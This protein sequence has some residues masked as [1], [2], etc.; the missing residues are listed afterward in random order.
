MKFQLEWHKLCSVFLL[1]ND[2][3]DLSSCGCASQKYMYISSTRQRWIGF[4]DGNGI[5]RKVTD[6]IMISI[7]SSVYDY[8]LKMVN[9][10]QKSIDSAGADT[11]VV[12]TV[13]DEDS[14]YYRFCGAA[15]A[16]HPLS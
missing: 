14:V 7:H 4:C 1:P 11:T 8:F 16:S 9:D 5:N 15:N 6:P 12:K 10:V 2:C 13:A 3:D